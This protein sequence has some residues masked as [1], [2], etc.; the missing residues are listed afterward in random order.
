MTT[1][2]LGTLTTREN[3][4]YYNTDKERT[5]FTPSQW[6]L[7]TADQLA[8][9]GVGVNL[10]LFPSAYTDIASLGALAAAGKLSSTLG[11]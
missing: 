3:P 8:E 6:Y 5:L 1:H 11:S 9:A 10:F 2:G 4:D 7:T